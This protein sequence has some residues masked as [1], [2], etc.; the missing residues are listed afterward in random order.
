MLAYPPDNIADYG[1]VDGEHYLKS[2]P[3]N[4][5]PIVEMLLDSP[6]KQE[7]L[8]HNALLL[9]KKN[10]TVQVRCRQLVKGL[11]LINQDKIDKACFENGKF[12]YLCGQKK[13]SD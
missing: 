7:E 5:K 9:A 6:A 2:D 4:I 1:F 10:H 13:I 12:I 3:A 11:Q 8:I